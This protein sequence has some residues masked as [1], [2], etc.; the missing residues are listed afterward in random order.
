MVNASAKKKKKVL[1]VTCQAPDNI[2]DI[3]CYSPAIRLAPMMLDYVRKM[4]S[5]IIKCSYWCWHWASTLIHMT[6]TARHHSA[7]QRQCRATSY[8]NNTTA[9]R[10]CTEPH[11]NNTDPHT[12]LTMMLT[13]TDIKLDW[14]SIIP[15][16][17]AKYEI[18]NF[19]RDCLIH[20]IAHFPVSNL[21]TTIP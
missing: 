7:R 16:K 2:I 6:R 13:L 4:R 15:Q 10:H 20:V 8:G 9:Q 21:S 3:N 17:S 1:S 19:K 18:R 14:W 12:A 5:C 11:C